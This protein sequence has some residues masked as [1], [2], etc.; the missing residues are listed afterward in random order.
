M[1]SPVKELY[2]ELWIISLDRVNHDRIQV[3]NVEPSGI[4]I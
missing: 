2:A 1:Q 3:M 4:G